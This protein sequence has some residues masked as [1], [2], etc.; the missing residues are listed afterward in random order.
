MGR[1]IGKNISK[2]LN[3]QNSQKFLVH[4]KQS[5]ANALKTASKRAIQE[6]AEAIGDL[7]GHKIADKITIVLKISPQNNSETNE[8]EII[9][10]RY[11]SPEKRQNYWWFKIN[12]MQ[13]NNG[14]SNNNKHI[15]AEQWTK[16]SRWCSV[17]YPYD[18]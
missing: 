5:A 11:I 3:S 13:Y 17:S 16:L 2:N 7:I 14:I 8:K 6:T 10:E 15:R 12:V 18:C 1:N 9:R 4:A